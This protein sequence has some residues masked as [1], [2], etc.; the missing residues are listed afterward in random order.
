MPKKR[1]KHQFRSLPC[2]KEES[3]KEKVNPID[4]ESIDAFIKGQRDDLAA[5]EKAEIEILARFLP[6]PL[7][8]EEMTEKIKQVIQRLG[9]PKLGELMTVLNAELDVAIAPR[10][11]LSDLAKKLV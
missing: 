4:S 8:E 1:A 11:Q 6:K 7:T 10:K 9:N 3:K 2:C 5:Q